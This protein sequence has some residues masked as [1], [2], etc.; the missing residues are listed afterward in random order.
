MWLAGLIGELW[1]AEACGTKAPRSLLAD[2]GRG[3]DAGWGEVAEDEGVVEEFFGGFAAEELAEIWRSRSAGSDAPDLRVNCGYFHVGEW[4][5]DEIAD[6]G[7]WA[8]DAGG[9]DGK[10]VPLGFAGGGID[11]FDRVA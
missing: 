6:D 5:V 10:I 7:G 2:V 8:G 3:V 9:G 11:G 1:H 4:N